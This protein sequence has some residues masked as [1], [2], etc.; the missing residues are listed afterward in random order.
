M[1]GMVAYKD[2]PDHFGFFLPLA[3]ITTVRETSEN[4]STFVRPAAA[5]DY[6]SNC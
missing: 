4:S 6:T 3:G 2:F 5:T 1:P